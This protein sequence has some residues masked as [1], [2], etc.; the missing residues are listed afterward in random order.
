MNLPNLSFC[1][2]AV[3]FSASAFCFS[4]SPPPKNIIMVV[5][6]GMGSHYPSAYRFYKNKINNNDIKKTIFDKHFVGTVNTTPDQGSNFVTDSAAAATALAAGVK[7]YNGAIGLDINKQPVETVMEYAKKIGKNTGIVVTSE[8]VHA[9]PASYISHVVNR[10]NKHEIA[11]QFFDQRINGK[12]KF[13]ILLGGGQSFFA[14]KDRNLITEFKNAGF[15]YITDYQAL[16]KLKANTPVLGLFADKGLP[17][18]LDET[19]K[20]R[21]T[22]MTKAAISHLENNLPNDKGFFLLVEAS[23]IDWAAHDNDIA[24]AMSEVAELENTMEFLAQ[25][26][27]ANNNTLVV[28]TA[29]HNTG[30]LTIGSKQAYLW[31]P[32]LLHK[33]KVSPATIAKN[34]MT[35]GISEQYLTAQLGFALSKH[36]L[37]QLITIKDKYAVPFE[38][39][40]SLVT[41]SKVVNQLQTQ[42]LTVKI[43]DIINNRTHTGWTTKGHTGS[44]VPLFAI[45]VAKEHFLGHQDNT[46]IANKIFHLLGRN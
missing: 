45:G 21:L 41:E 46:D 28:L 38:N 3:L 26:A 32:E 18:H 13:D 10:K 44:D 12:F 31:S 5:A 1:G 39:Q 4:D 34:L 33:I 40:N 25:Y 43:R 37:D 15:Q 17:A 24:V 19:N 14:R 16:T 29:D 2:I 30:G 42:S 36:E 7:T 23:Q 9:T 35:D 6:D 22:T 8:V 27:Q 20:N 11:D